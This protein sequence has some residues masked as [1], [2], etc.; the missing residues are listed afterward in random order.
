[1]ANECRFSLPV[2]RIKD[3]ELKALGRSVGEGWRLKLLG[4]TGE[5]KF[6]KVQSPSQQ[7]K[8]NHFSCLKNSKQQFFF[9]FYTN[10]FCYNAFQINFTANHFW[11]AETWLFSEAAFLDWL[12]LKGYTVVRRVNVGVTTASP[13]A[14]VI[15]T[16]C[17]FFYQGTMM[18]LLGIKCVNTNQALRILPGTQ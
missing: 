16:P 11:L 4:R 3:S 8:N 18:G 15:V 6:W 2:F 13:R 1:M 5:N 7:N 14:A 17:F 12:S 10:T 9:F